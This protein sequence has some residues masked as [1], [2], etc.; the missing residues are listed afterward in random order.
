[1]NR[2]PGFKEGC[3]IC[4]GKAT[5][6]DFDENLKDGDDG[7]RVADKSPSSARSNNQ[8]FESDSESGSSGEHPPTSNNDKSS[9]AM[10]ISESAGRS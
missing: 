7:E 10:Q 1:M 5:R 6:D 2:I 9:S 8:Q 3:M 4:C